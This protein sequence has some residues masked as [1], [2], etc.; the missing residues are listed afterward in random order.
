M[1]TLINGC[2]TNWYSIRK[3]L[4]KG[5]QSYKKVISR[6]FVVCILVLALTLQIVSPQVVLAMYTN[7]TASSDWYVDSLVEEL[8]RLMSENSRLRSELEAGPTPTPVT[9]PLMHLVTPHNVTVTA[10]EVMDVNL[11]I[12]N[13]GTHTA[14][15]VL[16]HATTTGPFV[17]EFLNNTNTM[18]TVTENS[19]RSLSMRIIVDPDIPSGNHTITITHR[20]RDAAGGNT[21]STDTLNVRVIGVDEEDEGTSNVRIGNF[22]SSVATPGADQSFT[23]TADIQNLGDAPAENVQVSIGNLDPTAVFLT[24]DL[25]QAFFASLDPGQSSQVTFTFRTARGIATNTYQLDFRLTYDGSGENRAVTPF[26]I[27]IIVPE[28]P[29]ISPNLEIRDLT[30]P[31]RQLNVGQSGQISFQLVNTGE[32]E[33]RNILITATAMDNTRMVPST[34]NR[35]NVRTLA[36]DGTRSFTFG[37]MPTPNSHT[38]SEP[39]RLEIQY[40]VQGQ[41]EPSRFIQYVALNVFNPEPEDEEDDTDTDE[42]GRTQIPRIIVSAY[43]VTPQIT[44]A[45]QNFEME[46]TFFNTSRTR[47]VNNI[48]ITLVAD[49]AEEGA[50]FTPVGGSNTLYVEFLAPG[51]HTTQT[52]TM[53]TIPD[54]PPRVYT[55]QVDFEY[56]DEDYYEHASSELLSIPVAQFSRLATD[57]PYI[58]IPPF[59][60]MWDSVDIEFNVI[61]SGRVT[62]Y[63]VW[64]R[65]EG[66]FD[67][68]EAN[69]FMSTLAVSRLN[70]YRG[71]IRPIEPGTHTGKI[72][73]YG[74]DSAGE[75]VEIYHE[76][77]IEVMDD[78]GGM[79]GMGDYMDGRFE[80]MHPDGD[81]WLEGGGDGIFEMGEWDDGEDGGILSQILSFVRRPL[82]W[83]PLAGVVAA[84][85]VAVVIVVQRKRS[86]LFFEDEVN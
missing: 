77:T 46:L 51:Q 61:N 23:I 70:T 31:S 29:T 24:S 53:F 85:V 12:R 71:R 60:S 38:Q 19:Q 79:D 62:L 27:N 34:S 48:R 68:S 6:L 58:N 75:I 35:H 7:T 81:Y 82:F 74:E 5:S 10:G 41:D 55:L 64:V 32:A 47:S 78:M 66:P 2:N 65:V 76:F 86:R 63:N 54:A 83:G 9:A 36:V 21:S 18:G 3:L 22:R 25:N 45:G 44:R 43:T 28:A 1:R 15:S 57:P 26:F 50:V 33:A 56:Q 67:T 20:F 52:V 17:I 14:F 40:E 80:H 49:V 69:I 4:P 59:I 16:S 37:F 42:P 11:I 73:V 72:I 30:V 8:N 13:I 39:I 84:S